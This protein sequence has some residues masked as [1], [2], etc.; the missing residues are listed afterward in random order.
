MQTYKK[1]TKYKT[2]NYMY[3]IVECSI[4][5]RV[6]RTVQWRK[7]NGGSLKL[8]KQP[9]KDRLNL[10]KCNG[11]SQNYPIHQIHVQ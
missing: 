1:S 8:S 6:T 11:A 9:T 2:I 10:S 7:Q 5:I 4:Y 3:I